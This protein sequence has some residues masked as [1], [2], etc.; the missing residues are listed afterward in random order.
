VS[1]DKITETHEDKNIVTID[2]NKKEISKEDLKR[3]TLSFRSL[4]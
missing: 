4:N 1:V 2:T 3:I